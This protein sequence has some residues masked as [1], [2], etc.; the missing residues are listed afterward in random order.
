MHYFYL[1]IAIIGEI[2]ATSALKAS[3]EFSNLIPSLIVI[4]GYVVAFYCLM[5]S[6]RTIPVGIAYAIWAGV[7]IIIVPFI[8]YILYRQ[9]LDLPAIIGIALIV[10]GVI[11]IQLFSKTAHT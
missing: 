10:S 9:A 6:L 1:A 11:V 5:L 4:I 2:V 8:A 7:G 3:N